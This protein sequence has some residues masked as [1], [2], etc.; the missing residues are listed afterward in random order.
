MCVE[1]MKGVLWVV[2]VSMVVAAW[3]P[4]SHCSKK[5]VGVARKEDIQYIKCHVCEKLAK[6][7]YQQVQNKQAEIAPKKVIFF[8]FC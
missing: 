2:V 5:P 7:L 6:E 1:K 4:F 8:S 3:M